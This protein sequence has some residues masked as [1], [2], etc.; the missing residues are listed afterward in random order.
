MI[1]DIAIALSTSTTPIIQPYYENDKTKI[2]AIGLKKDVVLE[3][4][5]APSKAQILIIQGTVTFRTATFSKSINTYET[6]E[7]PLE[8]EHEVI[9]DADSIFLLILSK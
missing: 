1:Q 5:T 4:H 8:V 7:I 2:I 9:G 3:K 6:Y